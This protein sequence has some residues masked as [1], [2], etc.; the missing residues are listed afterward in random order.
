MVA[1]RFSHEQ[2]PALLRILTRKLSVCIISIVR[3]IVLARLE[4]Y[5][6]TWNYVNA[7]VWSAAEPSMGVIAACLPSL[8]PFVALVLKSTHRGPTVI[9]KKYPQAS[10]SSGSSKSIWPSRTAEDAEPAGGF[11]R[12]ED[13]AIGRERDQRG[14]NETAVR[15]GKRHSTNTFNEIGLEEM[16][17]GIRVKNEIIVTSHA[18]DY[19]DRVY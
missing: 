6:V 16:N 14:K 8:R 4:A 17:S 1:C 13:T 5:D 2:K 7:A 11:T 12:L 18:W 9:S 10:D 3:L 15:G 19:K